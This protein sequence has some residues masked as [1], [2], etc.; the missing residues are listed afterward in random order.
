VPTKTP[1][2]LPLFKWTGERKYDERLEGQ[3]KDRER[4]PTNYHHGQ[5]NLKLGRKGSLVTNQIRVG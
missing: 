4:S 5:K 1:L 3:E 2:S